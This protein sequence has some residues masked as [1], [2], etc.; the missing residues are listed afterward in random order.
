MSPRLTGQRNSRRLEAEAIFPGSDA[1]YAPERG[2][3]D[4]PFFWTKRRAQLTLAAE[5]SDAAVALFLG[6][7]E[8]GRI[9]YINSEP[10]KLRTG[11]AYYVVPVPADAGILQIDIEIDTWRAPGDSRDL[12]V[13]VSHAIV[14][15]GGPQLAKYLLILK[16]VVHYELMLAGTSYGYPFDRRQILIDEICK[17][18]EFKSRKVLDIGSSFGHFHPHIYAQQPSEL[19]AL[20]YYSEA[21]KVVQAIAVV[22]NFAALRTVHANLD[23]EA[24]V[25]PDMVGMPSSYDVV[26]LSGVI[27]H[28]LAPLKVILE[29]CALVREQGVLVVETH[30]LTEADLPYAKIGFLDEFDHPEKMKWM[31]SESLLRGL[32]ESQGFKIEHTTYFTWPEMKKA[33]RERSQRILIIARKEARGEILRGF[34][35]DSAGQIATKPAPHW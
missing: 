21:L 22:H 34:S 11:F 9:A 35:L 16:A 8:E 15:A 1:A 6:N 3:S 25:R 27:Y 2:E 32:L 17:H 14:L 12:G 4:I 23:Y 13:M 5:P 18:V 7:P 30:L 28:V 26:L 10:L 19:V 20:D 31:L 29:G 24:I 33:S